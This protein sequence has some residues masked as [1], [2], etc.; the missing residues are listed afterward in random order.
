[1]VRSILATSPRRSTTTATSIRIACYTYSTDHF[2]PV[3]ATSN[4]QCSGSW[5]GDFLNYLTTSRMDALRRVL[6]GGWR[7]VDSTTETILQGAYFPQDGHSWGKEYQSVARDGYDI[8]NYAPLTAPDPGKYILFAV[9]TV[10]GN[11]NTYHGRLSGAAVPRSEEY[12]Q[13]RLELVVDR[14]P[15]CRKQVFY[16]DQQSRRLRAWRRHDRPIRA[17]RTCRGEFTTHG[18]IRMPSRRIATGPVRST[19][20]IAN[21]NNC[22]PYDA[23]QDNF[24]SI[25]EGKIRVS[26]AIALPVP[27][28]WRRCNRFP[29]VQRNDDRFATAGCYG[30]R[31]FGTCGGA[32][33]TASYRCHRHA[34]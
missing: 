24:M 7:Q 12:R 10:T 21:S 22:N 20:S 27:R 3:S 28:R 34:I 14:R 8:S 31:G 4:K 26:T 11:T 6:F 5:S 17:I 18:D 33:K 1:M 25:I 32:E 19:P 15:G 2:V 23:D 13:A 16:R 9:T 29:A 30:G